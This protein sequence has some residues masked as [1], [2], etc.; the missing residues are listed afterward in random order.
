MS[1]PG[2]EHLSLEQ[3]CALALV[4]GKTQAFS[5]WFPPKISLKKKVSSPEKIGNHWFRWSA[6]YCYS[7][8]RVRNLSRREGWGTHGIGAAAGTCVCLRA[9]L[10]GKVSNGLSRL[11]PWML[12]SRLWI[13]VTSF[14]NLRV[15]LNQPLFNWKYKHS[16]N[17]LFLLIN[18]W[19]VVTV[20]SHHSIR[21]SAFIVDSSWKWPTSCL[22]CM[23][24][25]F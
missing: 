5:V 21:M 7:A 2:K 9:G 12:A 11:R 14:L 18:T 4:P 15:E 16:G 19:P 23:V 6:M 22:D 24:P 8:I 17:S 10:L 25:N 13:S 20:G 3:G 1:F